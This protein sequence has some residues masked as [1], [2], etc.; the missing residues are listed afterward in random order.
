PV[1]GAL[2]LS[3]RKHLSAGPPLRK[4][5]R[6]GLRNVFLRGP[7]R[8][9]RLGVWLAALIVMNPACGARSKGEE[10]YQGELVEPVAPSVVCQPPAVC[11]DLCRPTVCA[12]GGCVVVPVD[13]DDGD[14]CT[15][16][17]CEPATGRCRY[18]FV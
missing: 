10:P 14:D 12:D 5:G 3:W 18:E 6:R 15:V 7:R 1:R 8:C 11:A 16:D 17:T 13:C 2:S 9:Q 4:R